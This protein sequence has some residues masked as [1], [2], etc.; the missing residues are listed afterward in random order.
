MTK[1]VILKCDSYEEEKVYQVIK[2]GFL[3]LGAKALFRRGEKILLKPNMVAA[4]PPE[5][6]STTHP[7]IFYSVARLLQEEG[8]ELSYGDSPAVHKPSTA[9]KKTGMM[10]AA[11]RL[12]IPL[13]DFEKG[14][15]VFDETARQNKKFHIANGV[16]DCDGVV[17]LPKL[18]THGFARMTGSVKNQFGCIPGKLKGEM[19]VKLPD[20]K[21]FSRMLV[22]LNTQ[23]SPRLYVMDGVMAM[24]GN[25]PRSGDL[26]PMNVI[27][28]SVDPIALDATVCRMMDLDPDFVETIKIGYEVGM[29]TYKAEE[30]EMLGDSIEDFVDKTFNVV[31]RPLE[32]SGDSGLRNVVGQLLLSK[33]VIKKDICVSCGLCIEMCPVADKAINWPK[34][35]KGR[36]PQY[37]YD[38]CI[39]CYCCQELCPESA[40]VIQT[41]FLRK[42]VDKMI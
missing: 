22:D 10:E 3:L 13:A 7:A 15:D 26:K 11:N 28:M 34:G 25:G 27:L 38:K 40:I 37:N 35:Q 19:H 18:K 14:H 6:G 41:P 20:A 29:G 31:R 1:V 5:K 36:T 4:D 32:K 30:I 24:E 16:L 9:A 12:G 17:S 21:D 2:K 8:L 39:R 33:P 23:V 42:I